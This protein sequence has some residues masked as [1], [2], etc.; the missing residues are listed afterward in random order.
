MNVRIFGT[1][2]IIL[3]VGA[4]VNVSTTIFLSYDNPHLPL[5][6][7]Q[8]YHT[9]LTLLNCATK[10]IPAIEWHKIE[11]CVRTLELYNV[12]NGHIPYL[13]GSVQITAYVIPTVAPRRVFA[14]SLYQKLDTVSKALVVIHECAHLALNVADIAYT[15]EEKFDTLTKDEHLKNAD[16]YMQTI[17]NHCTYRRRRFLGFDDS[18]QLGTSL[19]GSF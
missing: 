7:T 17:L 16:S 3:F 1:V 13:R 4:V 14:T 6:G 19:L 2:T 12:T 10:K 18:G 5:I 15:W 9:A 11:T 8:T